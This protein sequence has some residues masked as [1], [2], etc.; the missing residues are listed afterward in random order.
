[1]STCST[2]C[3]NQIYNYRC[4]NFVH[5]PSATDTAIKVY[6]IN[7]VFRYAL[8]PYVTSFYAKG[9]FIYILVENKKNYNT[10]LDF[11]NENESEC[12]L[13]KLNTIKRIFLERTSAGP[14]S[15]PFIPL[16]GSSI[17]HGNLVP[18]YDKT[19]YLGQAD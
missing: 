11:D 10:V 13:V 16:S 9:R 2:D 18:L 6:D 4:E 3:S 14:S 7:G 19:L 17:I 15:Y 1:M 5:T 8:D 12:G